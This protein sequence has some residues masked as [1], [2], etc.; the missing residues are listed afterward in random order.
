MALWLL[1]RSYRLGIR[2][3]VCL[4]KSATGKPLPNAESL[5]G[6]FAVANLLFGVGVIAILVAIPLLRLS[7]NTWASLLTI[8]SGFFTL[9]L[10]RHE[11]KRAA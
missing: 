10:W 11:P 7:F 9:V 1:W 5:V 4:V 8:V 2:R 6:T 3:E